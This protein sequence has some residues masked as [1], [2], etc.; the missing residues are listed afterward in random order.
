MMK[1]TPWF[2]PAIWGA[3]FLSGTAGLIYEVVWARYLDLL[4]GGTAYAHV[5][6]LAAFMGGMALGSWFFGRL[7][8]RLA[9]PLAA[10]CYLEMAVGL[11]G[12]LFTV[13]F[14]LYST[15]YLGLG[16]VIGVT[17]LGGVVNKFLVAVLLVG[18]STFLMGGTL[19][20]LVR[21]VTRKPDRVGHGV[22]A[23]YSVNSLGAVAGA[24]S[25]GFLIIPSLGL[26]A[27]LATAAAI[28][29]LVG[30]ALLGAWRYGGLARWEAAEEAFPS[31]A[32]D[33]PEPPP[34]DE[35]PGMEEGRLRRLATI[36]TWGVGFSGMIVMVYEVSWIRL[37]S[38]ILGSSTYSFT[39]ML[40]AFITGIALGSALARRL[41]RLGRPFLLFGIAQLAI[42]LA[43]LVT[44]PL[45]ARLPYFFLSLQST[46]ARTI[47]GYRIY[48]LTKY[49]FALAIMIPATLASGAALPLAGD[50][51]ARLK[52][53]VGLPIGQVWAT[54]T[55]GTIVGALAGG[56][57]LLPWL[58]VRL[59]LET[60]II[61]NILFG[62]WLLSLHPRV[63]SGVLRRLVP[64]CVAVFLLYLVVAPAWDRQAL[65][66]GVFRQKELGV[67]GQERF[68]EEIR[69]LEVIFYE[70]DVNGTVAVVRRGENITLVVNG[71]ADASTFMNDQITQ[72]MI[73]AIP[74][75]M[76]PQAREALVIGLGSG[77]TAGHLLRYP[78]DRVEIVEISP[79]V[80]EA[81]RFFDHINGRPLGDPRVELVLQDAKNYLL[82][83][84][85]RRYDLILSEPSNPWIAGIGGLFT[86]EYFSALRDR[87]KPGGAMAQW[88]HAYEQ[89]DETL[90]SVLLTF[91]EA[92]PFVTVWSM[93]NA[94]LLLVGSVR[95]IEW[96]FEA[97]QRALEIPEVK[98]D[99]ERI[100][101]RDLY[102]ILCRQLMSAIRTREAVALGGPRNTDNFPYLEY[103]APKAFFL[104][105]QATIHNRF[106]ERNRTLRNTDLALVRYLEGREPR[107]EERA[108]LVRYL[109]VGLGTLPRLQASAAAAWYLSAPDDPAAREAALRSGAA[110]QLAGVRE[111]EAMYRLRPDELHYQKVYAEV[112]I[113]TYETLR[114]SVFDAEELGGALLE[115]LPVLASKV[116]GERAYYLYKLGQVAYDRGA[117]E[118]A[119]EAIE[120]AVAELGI[121]ADPTR[122]FQ[123]LNTA[124]QEMWD[125]IIPKTDPRTP[126]D[127]V[128]TF[129]GRTRMKLGLIVEARNA[130]RDAFRLNPSNPIGAFYTVELDSD[131]S[132]G[133]FIP[134]PGS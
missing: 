128:L 20:I 9:D 108:N 82:T 59:T 78:V 66:A 8:D 110:Q 69:S 74:A 40:A 119:L 120:E 81:S 129:L 109:D 52:R 71:K 70:E 72:T 3:F 116:P 122:L 127:Q 6:V 33:E 125:Q 86:E 75:M 87:L 32:A 97:S 57:I 56:L 100:G 76:V 107:V 117:Y 29:I 98:A 95:P 50:V 99:L 24:L 22:A 102:T 36:A 49:L 68:R 113:N 83:R 17:G 134:P 4:M 43:L 61:L 11:Y 10:Y 35:F 130:F 96:D 88:I 132:S 16:G 30:I 53:K 114:S 44:L 58:G 15:L 23:L 106:D 46:L 42:G 111:A 93:S 124:P 77:Q 84:P 118:E 18:P 85:E 104:D 79:G 63:S 73:A 2:Y 38:T 105:R 39:L 62:I 89:S 92:F 25:G 34:Y 47:G 112:L 131:F 60:G 55:L 51:A 65:A 94:D 12:L 45:Y 7:V 19:P 80:V 31:M 90:G 13:L 64:A 27:T 67:A 48:E 37:L 21:A 121:A 26:D 14:S 41:A 123:A 91:S 103:Q 126:P 115:I 28:N 1:R 101:T 5:M 54:N 133:L